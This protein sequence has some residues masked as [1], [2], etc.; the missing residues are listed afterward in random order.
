[1]TPLERARQRGKTC[2]TCESR[3]VINGVSY[4]EKDGKMLHPMLLQYPG[5]CPNEV[6]ERNE[7][8]RTDPEKEIPEDS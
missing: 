3:T 2:R 8:I 5:P 4:C 1:M 6:R 7:G